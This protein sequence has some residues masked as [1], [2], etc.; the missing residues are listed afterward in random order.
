MCNL[1]KTVYSLCDE[2]GIT[3]G[4]MCND[5]G[6]RRSNMTELKMGRIK[7]LKPENLAKIS[8]YFGV[9]IDYLL[10]IEKT[11]TEPELDERFAAGY[12]ALN[13]KNRAI[14]DSLIDQLIA[15]QEEK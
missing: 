14:I 1:Y 13:E 10:G 3:V 9:T 7:T 2:N 5:I 11:P 12:S 8:E 6:M 4:K 15:T